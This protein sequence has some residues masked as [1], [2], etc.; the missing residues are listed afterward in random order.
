MKPRVT[1]RRTLMGFL[2]RG[3]SLSRDC[4]LIRKI[5]RNALFTDNLPVE[6]TGHARKVETEILRDVGC[7]LLGVRIHADSH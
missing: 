1:L 2:Q 4:A 7:L 6:S 3:K 5:Q